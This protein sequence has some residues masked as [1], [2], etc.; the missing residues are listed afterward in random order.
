MVLKGDVTR[1]LVAVVAVSLAG[2]APG[3]AQTTQE[4]GPDPSKMRV[5]VGPLWL[6]PTMSL[7]NLGV[8]TNVFNEPA[9]QGPKK[10]FT[11]TF[12]P[13]TEA[14]VRMARTWITASIRE[15]V[16]W[17]QKYASERSSNNSYS[18]GWK[19][20][21]NRLFLS[22][23]ANWASSRDRPGYEIDARLQHNET[24]YESSAELRTYSKTYVG[25]MGGWQ[26]VSFDKNAVFLGNSL[27]EAL[28]RTSISGG[29]TA[30]HQLTSL[31]GILFTAS[32]QEDRFKFSTLRDSNST[33]LTGTVKFDP[34]AL[35]KG[36]A[37]F[38]YRDF[39][40]LS[41]GV[42]GYKGSTAAVDLSYAAFGTTKFSATLTR[43]IQYSY[44]VNQPYYLQTGV[45]GSV[46]QQIFGPLDVIARGGAQ[47]LDYRDRAGAVVALVDRTDHVRTY[48]GGV[49][50]H[51]GKDTRLGFNIDQ[52]T[53]ESGVA[54][55]RYYGLRYGTSV[56]YGS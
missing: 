12:T 27:P 39:E 29:L 21:F 48:G 44:D 43:D 47:R 22:I 9:D 49:G 46:A 10:D 56:T 53:R 24:K 7:T 30:R 13:Q 15:D 51:F 35:L 23:N 31:T 20:P 16:V 32:R 28:N 5:K 2:A 3:S 1:A 45:T 19:V 40:P 34:A 4:G 6:N 38:G 55:R 25:V 18:L 33:A 54:S 50:Y 52:Q 36:A 8:D 14:W 41:A 42:P 17:Y 26:T 37:T 11:F